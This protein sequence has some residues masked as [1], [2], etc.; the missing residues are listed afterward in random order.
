M[1]Q[2][3]YTE[4]QSA[5]WL[6][7]GS[8][9]RDIKPLLVNIDPYNTPFLSS[10]PDGDEAHEM[11]FE[12]QL[13]S[14]RPPRVN[15]RSEF[16]T[17]TFER[18]EGVGRMENYCQIFRVDGEVSDVMQK[19]WKTYDPKQNE[20]AR[21]VEKRLK[22]LAGDMEFAIMANTTANAE[23]GTGT[24]AMTGG[25]PYFLSEDTM[26]VTVNATTETMTTATPHKLVTGKWVYIV[27]DTLPT[28][29]T[30]NVPYYVRTVGTTGTEF[31]LYTSLEGAVKHDTSKQVTFSN[32]GTN[33]SI[34]LNN[35]VNAGGSAFTL[36]SINDAVQ[37][38]TSR[39]GT[40]SEVWL[41][42][43]NR[44][45]FSQLATNVH[46]TQRSQTDHR[47]DEVVTTYETDF[48][49]VKANTH[50]NLANDSIYLIDPSYWRL[51]WFD[52][53]HVIPDDK[54][55]KEGSYQRFVASAIMG[56]EATQPLASA[57]IKN[58]A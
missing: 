2:V 30:A 21:L 56:L 10:I 49:V 41:S 38:A 51:R 17:Y 58:I 15:Q 53:P 37:M 54:L 9:Y 4:S 27:G 57:A 52:K 12:W 6:A 34:L 20:L 14:L 24:L 42:S 43:A 33:V 1:P 16:D 46:T 48:G 29:V 23:D 45:R 35:V 19:A 50:R 22:A 31:E 40:P 5:S 7:E 28:G 25:I 55:K 32:A 26:S 47:V 44:R 18:A 11:K 8:L 36:T 39:G 13:D 3:T